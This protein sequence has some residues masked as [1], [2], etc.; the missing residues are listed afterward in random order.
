MPLILSHKFFVL[1][2]V[3]GCLVSNIEYM[4]ESNWTQD[5]ILRFCMKNDALF[6]RRHVIRLLF[7]FY[8][9]LHYIFF[10]RHRQFVTL[11]VF[12]FCFSFLLLSMY[13]LTNYIF[14]SGTFIKCIV[15]CT[16]WPKKN[17]TAKMSHILV[18]HTNIN[19]WLFDSCYVYREILTLARILI[20]FFFA[21]NHS[22]A[23]LDD[24][25]T[26]TNS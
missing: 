4:Q 3:W 13:V 15:W 25:L 22:L 5:E 17:C 16:F 9:T 19:N 26:G 18:Y 20:Q 14:C 2:I 21:C 12:S 6:I 24:T 23:G 1:C 8:L 7:D 11:A 10:L